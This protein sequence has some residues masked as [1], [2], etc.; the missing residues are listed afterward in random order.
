M[1]IPPLLNAAVQNSVA[2]VLS[3]RNSLL[4]MPLIK[5]RTR[6]ILPVVVEP[7]AVMPSPTPFKM[8]FGVTAS[9]MLMLIRTRSSSCQ[10]KSVEPSAVL[11]WVVIVPII[12]SIRKPTN[13]PF[14]NCS[15]SCK[16]ASFSL[17]TLRTRMSKSIVRLDAGEERN[18][19][20]GLYLT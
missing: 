19:A 18:C 10:R 2:E 16:M 8:T 9:M 14:A 1:I 6:A 12:G 11:L 4:M 7:L 3:K 20:N 13:F 17:T 15:Q 5:I